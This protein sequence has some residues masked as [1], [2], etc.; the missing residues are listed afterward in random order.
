M[1]IK[2][3]NFELKIIT[4]SE[5]EAYFVLI[6][7]NRKRLKTYFPKTVGA[8]KDLE[9]AKAYLKKICQKNID[10][11]IYP[12]GVYRNNNL[13]GWISIK[14]MD[15]RIPK[16]ELGYYI[17][18]S[19]QGQ[20]IISEG[21]QAIVKY[22][23]EDLKV[24]KLFIRTG[25]DNVGS[26]KIALKNGFKK[27]GVLRSEFRIDNGELVDTNYFGLLRREFNN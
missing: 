20:G 3:E 26:Q 5:Y 2:L 10:K 9:Q 17:D 1:K 25:L 16:G 4:A 19:N 18:E 15:W 11:E 13:V 22:A 12:F 6:D 14:N 21:V 23:F 8:V 24:E 7:N 27:E